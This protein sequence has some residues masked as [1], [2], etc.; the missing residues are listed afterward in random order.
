MPLVTIEI[1]KKY[2]V[3][4]EIRIIDA[5]HAAMMEAI[6]TPDW[7][8]H[9]RLVVHEP[10]RFAIPPQNG[11]QFTLV[12]IDLFEG[13]SLNAKKV[14]YQAIVRNLNPI[15]IP[16]NEVKVLLRETTRDNFGI[17]GGVPASEV[18]LG[19]EVKI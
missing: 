14:L 13:R 10:H 18:E 11:N 5:V 7:D 16:P 15:G 9:I 6:K 8:K 4:D 1:R 12:T 3:E 2:S 17:R 19:F